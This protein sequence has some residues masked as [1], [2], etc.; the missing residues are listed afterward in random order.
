[1][2]GNRPRPCQNIRPIDKSALLNTKYRSNGIIILLISSTADDYKHPL[3]T[4]V[5]KITQKQE[6]ESTYRRIVI[7]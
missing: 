6:I 4:N 5:V 2:D 7:N 3:T 1:M